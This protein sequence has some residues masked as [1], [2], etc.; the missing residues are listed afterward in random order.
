M[1][2]PMSDLEATGQPYK[3]G[4]TWVVDVKRRDGQPLTDNACITFRTKREAQ[5]FAN[6]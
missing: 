1:R 5:E 6:D 3:V 2:M 4:G